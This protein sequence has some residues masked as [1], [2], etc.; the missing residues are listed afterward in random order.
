[1]LWT[2]MSELEWR[3]EGRRIKVYKS[4]ENFEPSVTDRQTSFMSFFK[5]V[6][7]G[8]L[9]VRNL[10]KNKQTTDVPLPFISSCLVTQVFSPL[11]V[12]NSTDKCQHFG[13]SRVGSPHILTL[14]STMETNLEQH[15]DRSHWFWKTSR[16][17][18]DPTVAA[19]HLIHTT[20]LISKPT[21]E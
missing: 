11:A 13:C 10:S 21:T 5:G 4:H 3:R 17:P 9:R 19:L 6:I 2:C 1:M 16:Y 20:Q 15:N 18:L 14:F 7:T 12:A 8:G